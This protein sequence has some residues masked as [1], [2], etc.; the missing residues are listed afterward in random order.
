MSI[1]GVVL[2]IV[3]LVIFGALIAVSS[4]HGGSI[5]FHAR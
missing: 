5:Y 1:A 2:G 4:Q 3:D